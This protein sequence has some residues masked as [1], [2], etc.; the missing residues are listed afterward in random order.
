M[1]ANEEIRQRAEIHGWERRV[2]QDQHD[3]LLRGDEMIDVLYS[4]DGSLHSAQ[5]YW[6]YSIDNLKLRDQTPE[7]HKK[8]TVFSWLAGVA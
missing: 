4:A 1:S 2:S 3:I 7:K 5:R 8:Q 6:F